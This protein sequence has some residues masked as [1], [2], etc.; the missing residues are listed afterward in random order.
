VFE[1]IYPLLAVILP[2]NTQS[3]EV[4]VPS[5]ICVYFPLIPWFLIPFVPT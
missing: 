4:I 2:L 1:P 3:L 5:V